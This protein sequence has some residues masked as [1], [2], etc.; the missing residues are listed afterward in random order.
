MI[1]V[2]PTRH[3][4]L[5]AGVTAGLRVDTWTKIKFEDKSNEKRHG[6]YYVNPL[7]L[8]ATFRAGGDDMGFFASFDLVPL[9]DTPTSHT[10]CFGFSLLF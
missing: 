8:D 10:L 9:F 7:K 2:R 1:E 3:F 4:F 6:D 5:A